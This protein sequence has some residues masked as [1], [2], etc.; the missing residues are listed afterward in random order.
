MVSITLEAD[1]CVEVVEEAL[2]HH[3]PPEIMNT[4]SHRI[5][6]SSRVVLLK[7]RSTICWVGAAG[8][9]GVI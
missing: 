4:D 8:L 6:A 9:S 3:G 1:F 5:D 2:A 7:H